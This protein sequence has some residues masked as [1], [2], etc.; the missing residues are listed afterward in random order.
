MQINIY[1][2]GACHNKKGLKSNFGTGVV[3]YIDGEFSEVFSF[4]LPGY[5]GTSNYAEWTGLLES[6]KLISQ[7]N[8]LITE[9][10]QDSHF[11]IYS[12]SQLVVNQYNKTFQ[13][14][15]PDLKILSQL[16]EQ[17]V[18]QLGF[19]PTLIWV[20]REQN[21][22]ADKYSK[23]GLELANSKQVEIEL[24]NQIV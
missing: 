21:K 20:P 8:K 2:D 1:F 6:L 18:K 10:Q 9:L 3:C 7:L 24:S 22:V 17:E 12:D 23:K 5:N 4:A 19:R 11:C 14:K 15:E 13:I 16:V